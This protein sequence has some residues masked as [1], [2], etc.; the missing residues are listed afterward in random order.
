MLGQIQREFDFLWNTVSK[1]YLLT[2]QIKLL[3]FL[4]VYNSL[5]EQN[6]SQSFYKYPQVI[7]VDVR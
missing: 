3:I 6:Q 4:L 7:E 1:I 5:L 2:F